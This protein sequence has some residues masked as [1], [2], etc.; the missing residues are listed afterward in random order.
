M[1]IQRLVFQLSACVGLFKL[2]IDKWQENIGYPLRFILCGIFSFFSFSI[3]ELLKG[4]TV[5][6][7][8]SLLIAMFGEP[9]IA[10]LVFYLVFLG[11]VGL[12]CAVIAAALFASLLPRT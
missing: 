11:Y 10:L 12:Y 2:Q 8:N 4:V 6:Q 7:Q 9:G 1:L 3:Y 5:E